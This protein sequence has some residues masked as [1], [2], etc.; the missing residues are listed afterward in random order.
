VSKVPRRVCFL[1]ATRADFGKLKS[2]MKS[3][4]D[5]ARLELSVF[6]TGMHMLARYGGT[7]LEIRRSGFLDLHTF[8]NQDSTVT[9]QMDL[10]LATTVQGLGHYLRELKPD[11]LVIHGDRIEALAGAIAGALNNVRTAH[12]EGGELSGTVDELLRHA[13][14]KLCHVHF[15]AN[16]EAAA[17]L[18]QLGEQDARIHVIGSPDI[19]VMLSDQLPPLTLVQERYEI[20]FDR[21]CIALLH[22]VTTEHAQMPGVASAFVDALLAS[23]RNFVVID[24]NNDLGSDHIRHELQRL[25]S[26][27]RFRRLPSL[28]F[29]YF[30]ALLRYADGMIGNS[31]A[32]IREAPVYGRPVINVG[33]RQRGRFHA[34]GVVD[35][36]ADAAVM[37]AAL[38]ALPPSIETTDFFGDGRSAERFLAVLNTDAFWQADLQKQFVDRPVP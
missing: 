12:V 25:D 28:R 2:L 26:H 38:S 4:Q 33:T 10:V 21:Y 15:V 6:V 5:D 9:T 37:V 7:A 35:V 29:E 22:P 24:P 11:L 20:P 27:P 32:G 23:G 14:S 16:E 17:R 1:T 34:P 30:L 8:I 36:P 18:R 19:D 3:V 13:V 31:S